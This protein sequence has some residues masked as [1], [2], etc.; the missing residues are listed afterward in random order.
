M[1]PVTNDG[2]KLVGML[3]LADVLAI[4]LPDFVRL[5]DN[6]DYVHDFGVLEEIRVNPEVRAKPISEVMNEPVFVDENSGLI[7][8]Y[9]MM[10]QHDLHDLPIVKPDGTLVGIA[11]RVDVGTAFLATWGTGELTEEDT[12]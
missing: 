2:E 5:I 3:G 7:R 9:T 11:S 4:F 10:L 8:A 1:L 12:A 6:V